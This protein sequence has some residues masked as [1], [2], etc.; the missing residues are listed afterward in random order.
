MNLRKLKAGADVD[1]AKRAIR[2]MTDARARMALA[3]RDYKEAEAELN[4]YLKRLTDEIQELDEA[5]EQLLDYQEKL[6]AER[7]ESKAGDA[8]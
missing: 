8:E 5:T 2:K 6:I 7:A 1:C 4:R 3:G